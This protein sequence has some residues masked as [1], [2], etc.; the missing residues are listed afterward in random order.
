MPTVFVADER[1]V[2]TPEIPPLDLARWARLAE[3]VLVAEGVRGDAEVS[4]LF[5][6]EDEIAALNIQFMGSDGPTDVLSF[7]IDSD[8]AEPGRWPDG[9]TD[10]P[11]RV[12]PDDDDLPLLLGDIVIAPAV[13]LRN[14]PSHAGTFDDEIALLVV[15]GLL[16]ILGMD[17]AEDAERATMQRRERELLT[18]LHGVL[19]ADP[20]AAVNVSESGPDAG[21]APASV[22][23]TDQT[24]D[25]DA[26]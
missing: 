11:D 23:P 12:P 8:M 25:P 1:D 21:S 4:V 10:G 14:A 2:V 16:H 19:T 15:H 3:G 6:D 17:H 9:G 24:Q 7:P 22:H 26:T 20:W 18:E 5:I 13:A